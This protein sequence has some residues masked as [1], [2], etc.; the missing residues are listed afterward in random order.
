M[1]VAVLAEFGVYRAYVTPGEP[2]SAAAAAAVTAATTAAR[3][4][5]DERLHPALDAVRAAV[6]GLGEVTADAAQQ[7][8]RDELIVR[9][10]QTTGP[11]LAKG[12]EDTAF[13][14]W[15]RLAA[16]NEVGGSPDIFG[17]S[18]AEFHAAA[19]RLA[20]RWPFTL[21]TL[22]T[23]D[24]KRQED[25]RAR[26]AVLAE[27][28]QEWGHQ[29]AE[30]HGLARW[31]TDGAAAEATERAPEPDLEY[32]MWQTLVGAWLIGPERLGEYIGKAMHEAKTR[33]SWTV[34]RAGYESA[35]LGLA[36]AVLG[37]PEL[38][39]A[40]AGFVAKIAPDARVNTLGAKLVQL[41]MPGVADVYQG[42]ELTGLSL[43]DPDNR[44]PVDYQRRRRLLA[45]LDGRPGPGGRPGRG[46]A[47]GDLP[48]AVAAARSPGLVRRELHPA[49]ERRAGRRACVR[50]PARR[51]RGHRRHPAARRAAAARRLGG[52]RPAAARTALAG[53]ADRSQARR[54]AAAAFRADQAASGGVAH[55]GPGLRDGAGAARRRQPALTA[56]SVWAPAAG[57]VEVE[58]AGQRY[59]MSQENAGTGA[60]WWT[61]DVPDV[62]VGIDYGFRLDDGEPLP[63]PRSLR[64]PF[65][66]KGLSRTYDHSAFRWTD[67]RWRGGALHGSV[68]YELHVGTFTA[69]GTFDAAIGRLDHLRDLGVHAVELMP[70]A[71][72]P[73]RHGWG[74]DGINLW[75][76]HEPYGGPDGLKRFVDACH[77][78]GLAVLLDVVYNHVGIGNRLGDFGPY[79]TEAHVTPWGP[80]VNL[81]QPGSDEVRA[82]L[83]GN[84]LM[85]LRDYHLDGLRLDAV[86]AL[87]DHR[88]LHF[89]EE[90]ATEVHALAALLNR[91]L[92][93]IA[94]SDTNDPRLVTSREAG[95]YGLA[96]QWSDDFHHAVHAAI[97]GERQ[98][99]YCDFGSLETLAK[100]YTRV[101]FH[102]GIWSAFRGRTHGRQ[103]DVFRVPAHRF[104]GYLQNH[105]QVG[106]RA[107]GDRIAATLSPE[108]VK[109]GAG[110]VLTSP[111]TPMLFMG[112]EWGADTPW[113]YFTDHIEPWLA[114]AVA[115]GRKAEFA[116]HGWDAADVPDPQ[117]EATFLRSKLDWEQRHHEPHL[118]LHAWYRELIALRR[119]RPELTDPRLD[120]VHADFDEDARWL[121][122]RRGRLR[123][124]A[125]LGTSAARL[126]LG[127]PGTGVLAASSPGVA[128]QRDVVGDA[129]RRLRRHRD[130]GAAVRRLGEVWEL[131]GRWPSQIGHR[132]A[133]PRSSAGRR[134][135]RWRR[136]RGS[137]ARCRPAAPW[138][139]RWGT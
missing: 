6:L 113:Q 42:C 66:I 35:V 135:P 105:D 13:Y 48:G 17:I 58:V 16:L 67:S 14:R 5:L 117:D 110:L 86:H 87:E 46:E 115:E 11:V 69:E 88:A 44:R 30:W 23:H 134:W 74:Y 75:A 60:G 51:P 73:G 138:A 59:P 56:F 97:T 49:G 81:D 43:V 37:D 28:P 19:G 106:N 112:E 20:R 33:T 18:P 40:I 32:L 39:A 102:D 29:V 47:A 77:E 65:G 36:D 85:W 72:F 26:L 108:L 78:R 10:G 118:G 21:T 132:G 61:A 127:Q 120:R 114:K 95:G 128:I 98:G 92:I 100:T 96:A 8:A 83:I 55:P 22:S 82:Y 1:L 89:L 45:A 57:K 53:R 129:P 80:A 121:L 131:G 130:R 50:L 70:V 126:P 62:A 41:T 137:P 104:L 116:A 107:I 12:V 94:E 2:P 133:S 4:G 38:T 7:A 119:A 68:I 124:A 111:Y 84:A 34:R 63:D 52:H 136:P 99:Y 71:A 24:T 31:L 122:V 15:S 93:L 27:W 3:D 64:Q 125:N 139:G 91:E 103:V 25:V 101:F 123:I 109:V 79:F 54:P 9:F 90:L 76:V